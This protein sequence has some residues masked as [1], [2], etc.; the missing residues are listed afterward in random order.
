MPRSI[1]VEPNATFVL[2]ANCPA[3]ANIAQHGGNANGESIESPAREIKRLPDGRSLC[4]FN[5]DKMNVMDNIVNEEV[6]RILSRY[7]SG[8]A[9][10]EELRDL[11][12]WLSESYENEK[13]F[14]RLTLL[15]QYAGQNDGFPAVDT[16]KALRK[17]KTYINI[18]RHTS[19]FPVNEGIAGQA[20]ND[21]KTAKIFKINNFLKYAA[22]VALLAVA[23][24]TLFYFV[25]LPSK[26]VQLA[27]VETQKNY[28]LF[29]NA[30]VTLFAGSEISYNSKKTNDTIQLKGKATFNVRSKSSERLVVQAGETYIEDIGTIFT[31][32]ATT[33]DKSV[34]V[35]V[36]EGEVWFYTKTN[37]GIYLKANES[38]MYNSQTKQ[39]TMVRMRQ[40]SSPQAVSPQELV[41]Q[42]TPLQ[43]AINAIK[44]HYGVDIV[45]ASKELNDIQ[46]NA[47][48]GNSESIEYVLDIIS[49]SLSVQIVKKDEGYVI[50]D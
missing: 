36:T 34:T 11:D 41:F 16:Q 26:T 48:F 37:T 43:E 42:N 38:A 8:E 28:K 12:V 20:R 19:V 30:D 31:I 29:D 25:N 10:E 3:N 21:V 5:L 1:F 47:S 39:F 46:L 49:T 40:T 17:F 24:F 32:D 15:Y 50:S 27:A 4:F 45:I 6:D 44:L 22:A 2:R 9:T 13:E 18:T 23:S 14:H 35:E 7:F 33:P